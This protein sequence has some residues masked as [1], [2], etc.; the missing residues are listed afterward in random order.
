MISHVK[1][2]A[3]AAGMVALGFAGSVVAQVNPS[4]YAPTCK[5]THHISGGDSILILK[6]LDA[7]K[8]AAIVGGVLADKDKTTFGD[9]LVGYDPASG[10]LSDFTI[11]FPDGRPRVTYK[12]TVHEV[13]LEGDSLVWHNSPATRYGAR[14]P[15][16]MATAL[17]G[18]PRQYGATQLH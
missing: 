12:L 13:R 7:Q 14:W 1:T 17:A 4:R 3:I 8:K 15:C 11:F 10:R 2:A 6:D 16:D 9:F 5:N 18:K